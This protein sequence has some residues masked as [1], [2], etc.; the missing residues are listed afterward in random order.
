MR[1]IIV[2]LYIL[3]LYQISKGQSGTLDPSFGSGGFIL[4]PAK[5][6]PFPG[7]TSRRAFVNPDNT[8][9]IVLQSGKGIITRRHSDGS[10]DASYHNNGYSD[11]VSINLGS[12]AIQPDG[13]IVLAGAATQANGFMVARYN[14]DGTLDASFGNNGVTITDFGFQIIYLSSVAVT[15]DGKIIAGGSAT[16]NGHDQFVVARY[17]SSG[18]I[19]PSFGSGGFVTTDFNTPANLFSLALQ[20]DGKIVA[21]GTVQLANSDFALTRYNTD[22]SPDMTFNSTGIV[23]TDFGSFD[24]ANAVVINNEGKIYIGGYSSDASG[25]H[26]RIA[27]YNNDGT[28]D[29]NFNAGS[30]SVLAAF[31]NSSDIL[32]NIQ[33]QPD[34]KI[35]ASGYTNLNGG[36]TDIELVR[37]NTDGSIDDGFGNNSNGLV[38]G[39]INSG[40][41]ADVFLLTIQPD[42]KILTGGYNA[43]F[44]NSTPSSP[45]TCFRYNPDGSPDNTFGSDGKFADFFPANY[46]NYSYVFLQGDG[47]LLATSG[48]NVNGNNDLFVN[49]FNADGTPDNTF[50]QNGSVDLN[51]LATGM[52]YFQPDGKI[53]ALNYSNSNPNGYDILL[54]RYLPDGSPDPGFGSGGTVTTDLGGNE[55]PYRVTFQPDGKIVIAGAFRDEN[56]SDLLVIRY[57]PDGSVDGSFG[58]GGYVRMNLD[59]EDQP[60]TIAVGPDGK[61][62][63]G[64]SGYLFPPDFSSFNFDIYFVRLN[65][66]GSMDQSFADQGKLLFYRSTDG[67]FLLSMQVLNNNKILFTDFFELNN[68]G[69]FISRLYRLNADGTSDTNFGDNGKISCDV[70][71]MVLQPDQKILVGGQRPNSQGN[72]DFTLTRFSENGSIDPSFGTNGQTIL[73]FTG[74][75]NSLLFPSLSANSLFVA[76]TGIEKSG[77]GV[78]I[79]AKFKID[80]IGNAG[81]ISCPANQTVNTDNNSCS[82]KVNNIDPTVTPVGTTVNYTLAGATTGTG[83][84]SVSGKTFNKGVTTVTYTLS[85]DATKSC[86]FTVTVNDKQLPVIN[87]LS[88]SQ[89]TLWPPDH[90]LKDITVNYSTTDNCGIANTQIS[91]SSDEPVQ[92]REK[93]DQSPDWQILDTHH[94]RLR[95]ERLENGNGRT[96]SIKVT[97]TDV[98]GNK[99][100][101]TVAV[102]VPKS[103]SNP[104]PNLVVT[105]SPNPSHNSFMVT[106][107]SNS[108]DKINARILNN[109]GNVLNTINNILAPQQLKIGDKLIPGI[110]FLEVTQS[111]VT[112]TIK[113]IKQ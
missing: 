26:F 5:I 60:Q 95:A 77:A 97:T 62:V 69:A 61:I 89:T 81:S 92:S 66:D 45:Y 34:G 100:T 82:A 22:G 98:S 38:L 19:D 46:F 51:S 11:V 12:A 31:G 106:I 20:S 27:R 58:T 102:K 21:G 39:D 94:I 48:S 90:K 37:I 88:V 111:G 49:R 44:S 65:P 54:T 32:N 87:N 53:I 57:N 55:S 74:L 24:N 47:K 29:L 35:L 59:N 30:G 101:S 112:K 84:G 80:D 99:N 10:I 93:D 91:V 28:P 104:H 52:S 96:Y 75:D 109:R 105:A 8:I 18:I 2:L 3:S 76:G 67:N 41:D 16:V 42:G 70:G 25:N 71:S 14:T 17:S 36:N 103:I 23:T 9:S 6:S 43:D 4:T 15:T 13:K 40:I 86:S 33:L 1:K 85:S 110:Y 73:S 56:G 79:I 113:L 72:L 64:I 108:Q 78:G 68:T 107:N 7:G 63:I 50:G 83:S